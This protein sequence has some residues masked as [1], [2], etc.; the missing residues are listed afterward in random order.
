MGNLLSIVAIQKNKRINKNKS[1]VIL[2]IKNKKELYSKTRNIG[3]HK[4]N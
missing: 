1:T 2:M 3:F 4:I